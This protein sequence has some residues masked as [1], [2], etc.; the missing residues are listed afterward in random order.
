MQL[1]KEMQFFAFNPKLPEKFP[2]CKNGQIK[3]GGQISLVLTK[4]G[5]RNRYLATLLPI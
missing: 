2:D 3:L 4:S 1:Q 5:D